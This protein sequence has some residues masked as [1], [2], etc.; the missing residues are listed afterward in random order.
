MACVP[1]IPHDSGED[2]SVPI[3][4][5]SRTEEGAGSQREPPVTS[6]RGF[7]Q[8]LDDD[9]KMLGFSDYLK[10]AGRYA[11]PSPCAVAHDVWQSR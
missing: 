9:E 5:F 2:V 4:L 6:I 1:N 10:E 11:L 7:L 8:V 3:L